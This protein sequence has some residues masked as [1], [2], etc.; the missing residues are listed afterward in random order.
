MSCVILY[1]MSRVCYVFRLVREFLGEKEVELSLIFDAVE[2]TDMGNYTCNVENHIG[3]S[4]ASTIL[5][6]KGKLSQHHPI[7]R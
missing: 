7:H 1:T 6:K 5:Q 3:R 4:S 2:E